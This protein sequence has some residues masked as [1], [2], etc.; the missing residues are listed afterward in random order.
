MKAETFMQIL[1]RSNP[2]C[3]DHYLEATKY[4]KRKVKESV[5]RKRGAEKT[6]GV[7]VP[8]QVKR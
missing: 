3:A 4:Q 1:G 8:R 2:A 6:L 5:E 7:W